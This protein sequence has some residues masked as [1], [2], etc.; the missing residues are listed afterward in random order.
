MFQVA[1]GEA[2]FEA[3]GGVSGSQPAVGRATAFLKA[4]AHEGR[5]EIL[6]LL[7]DGERTVGEIEASLGLSQAA[8][9]QQLMRLRAE[10]LVEARRDGRFIHYRLERP[11][12]RAIIRE[13]REAFC[14]PL[15]GAGC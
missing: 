9:S 7:G 6:C 10:G 14:K 8:V 3:F 13:L 11:E 1:Q 5:L 12:V 2:K 4:I 15:D